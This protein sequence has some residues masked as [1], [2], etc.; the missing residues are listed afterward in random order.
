MQ[1]AT[2]SGSWGSPFQ[3]AV[4]SKVTRSVAALL[5]GEPLSP[6][7]PPSGPW[8]QEGVPVWDGVRCCG[9]GL[10]TQ[11]RRR[12]TW[13]VPGASFASLPGQSSLG[14][15]FPVGTLVKPHQDQPRGGPWLQDRPNFVSGCQG[16]GFSQ[17][18]MEAGECAGVA[19][20]PGMPSGALTGSRATGHGEP[21][22]GRGGQHGFT[23][24]PSALA[25]EVE[26]KDFLPWSLCS[27]ATSLLPV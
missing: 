8:G 14:T 16:E 11:G 12:G 17:P 3:S 24:P 22:Q 26:G 18:P 27:P 21:Q 23:V 5:S 19:G 10:P 7:F 6:H 4:S 1:A 2:P 13:K 15:H 25:A 9:L 20:G